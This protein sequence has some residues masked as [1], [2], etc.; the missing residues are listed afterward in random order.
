MKYET[1]RLSGLKANYKRSYEQGDIVYRKY[2][3]EWHIYANVPTT[4]GTVVRRISNDHSYITTNFL[5]EMKKLAKPISTIN[6][7]KDNH[8]PKLEDVELIYDPTTNRIIGHNVNS[9]ER[10]KRIEEAKKE[11]ETM[12]GFGVFMARVS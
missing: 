4:H 8:R 3:R 2:N 12:E 6:D 7:K 1:F 9:V 10:I 11:Y 5:D